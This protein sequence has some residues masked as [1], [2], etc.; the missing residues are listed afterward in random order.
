[1][2]KSSVIGDK[3]VSHLGNGQE[4][5]WLDLSQTKPI[6]RSDKFLAP[7]TLSLN[8]MLFCWSQT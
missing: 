3:T 6:L 1:M 4:G 7:L 2:V 8:I 5:S